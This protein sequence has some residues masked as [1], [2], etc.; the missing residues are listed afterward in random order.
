MGE[1][2]LSSILCSASSDSLLPDAEKNLIPLSSNALC[3]AEITTPPVT[4]VLVSDM[5][6][7]GSA[8]APIGA[9]QLQQLKTPPP[10]PTPTCTQISAYL[11]QSEPLGAPPGESR[12][13]EVNT[14]PAA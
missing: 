14:F 11:Y 2:N 5:P 4:E 8:L 1:L 13:D 6:Q 10:M 7:P 3:E 12:P 9:H